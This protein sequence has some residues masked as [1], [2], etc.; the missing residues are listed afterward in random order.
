MYFPWLFY[1]RQGML[2]SKDSCTELRVQRG[3][4]SHV[5]F[6]A[7]RVDNGVYFGVLQRVCQ[8]TDSI[9]ASGVHHETVYQV[10]RGKIDASAEKS[11]GQSELRNLTCAFDLDHVRKTSKW[12]S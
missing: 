10:C 5:I 6:M 12:R 3:I 9:R 8:L 4:G 11:A 1:D 2:V 7:M